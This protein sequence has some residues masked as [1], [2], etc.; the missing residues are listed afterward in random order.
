MKVLKKAVQK[1]VSLSTDMYTED[2]IKN[3][4]YQG[5]IFL[6]DENDVWR[7]SLTMC[8]TISVKYISELGFYHTVAK[9]IDGTELYVTL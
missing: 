5:Y 7:V 6:I 2:E 9:T 3:L 1:N 8:E 4:E